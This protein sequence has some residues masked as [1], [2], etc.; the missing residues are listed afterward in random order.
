MEGSGTGAGPKGMIRHFE[1]EK[2]YKGEGHWTSK[3][4]EAMQ[5]ESFSSAVSEGQKYRLGAS[6]EFV[7]EI[8]GQ[9]GFRVLLPA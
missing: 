6:C 5:F 3:K 4:S 1:T 7:V 8:R 2:Y 9:V